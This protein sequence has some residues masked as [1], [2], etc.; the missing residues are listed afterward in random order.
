MKRKHFCGLGTRNDS[1]GIECDY[2]C[3]RS[4]WFLAVRDIKIGI[5]DLTNDGNGV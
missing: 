1:G 3:K 4:E 5:D 2:Y